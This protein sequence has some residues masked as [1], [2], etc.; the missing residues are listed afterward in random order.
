MLSHSDVQCLHLMKDLIRVIG[1]NT[2]PKCVALAMHY[3]KTFSA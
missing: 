1:L 3:I 2:T